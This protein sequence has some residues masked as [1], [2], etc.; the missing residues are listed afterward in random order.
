MKLD[1]RLLSIIAEI[2]PD[3]KVKDLISAIEEESNKCK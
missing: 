3:M 1:R 2:N